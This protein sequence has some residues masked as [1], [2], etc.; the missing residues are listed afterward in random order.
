MHAI[1]F[2]S[3]PQGTAWIGSTIEEAAACVD[4]WS[5]RLA[6][7]EFTRQSFKT[8]VQ[9][10]VPRHAVPLRRFRMSRYPV[11]NAQF[12]EFL[13]AE[14]GMTP[15]SMTAHAGP[16][17][18]V[19]GVTYEECERFASWMGKRL[20][21]VCRLPTE[22][23]WEYAARG[24]EQFRYPYGNDFDPSRCNVLE[25]GIGSTTPVDRFAAS[26]SGFGI[27]DMAGNVEEWTSSRYAPYP[28]GTRVDDALTEECGPD[29]HVL[30]GGSFSRTGDLTRCARR[31]GP[32]PGAV[33]RFRGFRLVAVEG[34]AA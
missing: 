29:Y 19:W 31:H 2:I 23:E 22:E 1:E 21:L 34:E 25:S 20:G 30:R 14:S 24:P 6:Q 10:E 17:S 33:Y 27:C 7:P 15:E 3:I 4:E 28:G 8:W 9:K 18:P 12:D 32:H 26:P 16:D 5:T 13:S 11:T